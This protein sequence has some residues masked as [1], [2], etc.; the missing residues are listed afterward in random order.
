MP[1]LKEV[2]PML[3]P[4]I[5]TFYAIYP[6]ALAVR[7]S[8][9]I[10]LSGVLGLGLYVY[11]RMPFKEVIYVLI[12][13]AVMSFIFFTASWINSVPDDYF[14]NYAKSQI[15]WI[16]SAYLIVFLIFRIHRR[17]HVTTILLYIAVAIGVQALIAF[18][19]NRS[20][21]VHDFFYSLQMQVDYTE[22]VVDE[23]GSQRIVGYG[24]AF[25]GAG[26]ISG[27]GLI[28]ISYILMRVRLATKEF[29]ALALLYV[30][31]FYIGLFMA[32]TT[33]VGMAFG[34][35]L[36][37][38]LY[39]WDNRSIRKQA[40]TFAIS[41]V[42]LMAGGYLFA[43]FYFPAFSDWA[44][45]LFRNFWETGSLETKS[46]SGLTEMFLIPQDVFTLWF[47]TGAMSFWG[48]DVGFSRLLYYAGIPGMLMYF[49]YP[50][51]VMK[52]SATRDW[53]VNIITIVLYTY[54]IALNFKGIIDLNIVFYLIFFY[55]MFYKYYIY[56]PRQY[57]KEVKKA[58]YIK[59]K[60]PL[61]RI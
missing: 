15:A 19:M 2:L 7:G 42:F 54:S 8:S 61:N 22:E 24:I 13:L 48:S 45:E 37:A 4:L 6:Q 57:A 1:K 12:A 11:H 39:I 31:I 10:L 58:K 55:F 25:F 56:M 59:G 27:I 18:A 21:S 14:F 53:A 20:E 46:S 35:I 50:L 47:G 3:L 23:A 41:S 17:P 9:F 52:Y 60:R 32:R 26:A 44:F 36:I 43:M 28:V 33:I 30:F 5:L 38:I 16:F 34:M 49:I 29:I 40:K 51:I